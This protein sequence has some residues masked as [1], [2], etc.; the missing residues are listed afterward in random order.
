MTTVHWFLLVAFIFYF[1]PPFAK[2]QYLLEEVLPDGVQEKNVQRLLKAVYRFSV[3]FYT[4]ILE[5]NADRNVFFSPASIYVALAMLYAGSGGETKTQLASALHLYVFESDEDGFYESIKVLHET[6]T[7]T[8]KNYTLKMANRLFGQKG[9][10]VKAEYLSRTD[11]YFGAKL[12]ALDFAKDPSGSRSKINN[13]VSEIT[14]AKIIELFSADAIASDTVLALANA[15]Y[16]NGSWLYRF[17]KQITKPQKFYEAINSTIEIP[18]MHL[19]QSSGLR[20]SISEYRFKLLELPYSDED[21]SMIIA[22]DERKEAKPNFNMFLRGKV[23]DIS[24]KQI[25]DVHTDIAVQLALPK[26]SLRQTL[27]LKNSLRAVGIWNLF[28]SANLSGITDS[29]S[30]KLSEA[31]HQAYVTVDEEG[32]QAAAA[33]GFGFKFLSSRPSPQR[34]IIDFI[35]ERP[36]LML[37]VEKRTGCILFFGHIQNPLQAN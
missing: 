17:D 19:L 23:A 37:V 31:I 26:F 12:E 15:V 24:W 34:E 14:S 5:S 36:F 30:L 2:A 4:K 28:G 22:L 13:W 33:T 25:V 6:L 8:K 29:R 35:V 1:C 21:V 3:E 7:S 27:D 10:D 16:F 20:Y 32:T 9:F 11:E 18:M